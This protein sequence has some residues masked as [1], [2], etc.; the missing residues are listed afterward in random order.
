MRVKHLKYGSFGVGQVVAESELGDKYTVEFRDVN[1]VI[2]FPVSELEVVN[3]KAPRVVWK[4]RNTG[5][6]L[7]ARQDFVERLAGVLETGKDNVKSVRSI[8]ESLG[9]NY[10]DD[11]DGKRFAND[12]RSLRD[13]KEYLVSEMHIP[14]VSIQS[15]QGGYYISNDPEDLLQNASAFRKQAE[16][17]INS[18]IS[19][20][21]LAESLLVRTAN[22]ASI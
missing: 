5:E 6:K 10:E 21:F 13:A 8:L 16:G 4:D 19:L 9:Q 18:A 2:T 17:L 7:S 1:K 12:S 22:A 15:Q 3:E 11:K 14:I 20:E